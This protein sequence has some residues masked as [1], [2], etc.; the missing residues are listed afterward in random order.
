M[1]KLPW[2]NRR[3]IEHAE[4]GGA[5]DGSAPEQRR[6][7]VRRLPNA[8]RG[9]AIGVVTLLTMLCTPQVG[10]AAAPSDAAMLVG[11]ATGLTL[12]VPGRSVETVP[13]PAGVAALAPGTHGP[14]VLADPP[15]QPPPQNLGL[16]ALVWSPAKSRVSLLSVDLS[17]PLLGSMYA[18]SGYTEVRS[19][20]GNF[21]QAPFALMGY[22]GGGSGYS[23]SVAGDDLLPDLAYEAGQETPLLLE[24]GD[25]LDCFP[26]VLA[27]LGH[28]RFLLRS[29]V[30]SGPAWACRY[31]LLT[32]HHGPSLLLAMDGAFP[33]GQGVAAASACG[34]GLALLTWSGWVEEG[35]IDGP[36]RRLARLGRAVDLANPNWPSPVG[37]ACAPSGDTLAATIDGEARIWR[38]EGGPLRPITTVILPR[39]TTSWLPLFGSVPRLPSSHTWRKALRDAAALAARLDVTVPSQRGRVPNVRVSLRVAGRTRCEPLV[40]WPSPAAPTTSSIDSCPISSRAGWSPLASTSM[41]LADRADSADASPTVVA[42]VRHDDLLLPAAGWV[43][44]G[45][46]LTV[47]VGTSGKVIQRVIQLPA[48]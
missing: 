10:A 4:Y 42:A 47:Q 28:G 46:R 48:P 33:S 38:R 27:L 14:V 8:L 26:A 35:R 7:A 44:L 12:F 23:L 36:W 34:N 41:V 19:L 5:P 9:L 18:G 16:A 21:G 43:P 30:P 24:G 11:S 25:S 13:L 37:I 15:Y 31:S 40:P 22:F 29:A 17:T 20:A 32:P 6:V 45:A 2:V 3:A 1:R 39:G